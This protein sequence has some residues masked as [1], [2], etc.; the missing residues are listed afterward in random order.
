MISRILLS[1]SAAIMLFLGGVHLVYTAFTHKLNPS[2]GQVERAMRRTPIRISAQNPGVE[3]L[4]RL[5]CA[6]LS[7]T[8]RLSALSILRPCGRVN[9]PSPMVRTKFPLLRGDPR[10]VVLRLDSANR[11]KLIR[12]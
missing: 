2:E 8:Q 11:K 3:C 10:F 7:V 1:A 6:P 4:D 5:Q 9:N 12:C